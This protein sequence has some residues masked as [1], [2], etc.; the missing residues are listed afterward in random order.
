MRAVK[1]LTF[2]FADAIWDDRG[3]WSVSRLVDTFRFDRFPAEHNIAVLIEIEAERHEEG[4]P[5][6]V[7]LE[8]IDRAGEVRAR[9]AA[10]Q[11]LGARH[12]PELPSVWR[13]PHRVLVFTYPAPGVYEVRLT[14]DGR[15]LARRSLSARHW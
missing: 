13:F 7:V 6:D 5:V 8:L 10:T 12:D 15:T 14:V 1:C 2:L 9:F 11:I 3:T 4:L